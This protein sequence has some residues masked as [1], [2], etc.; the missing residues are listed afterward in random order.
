MLDFEERRVKALE[1]VSETYK[2]LGVS[3]VDYSHMTHHASILEAYIINGVIA[4][5]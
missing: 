5:D 3:N 2:A 4:D 1:I